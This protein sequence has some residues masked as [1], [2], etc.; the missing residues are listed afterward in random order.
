MRQ[1]DGGLKRA[2][3][4]IIEVIGMTRRQEEQLRESLVEITAAIDEM[5]REG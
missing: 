1:S 2:R 4:R 5:E 3:G